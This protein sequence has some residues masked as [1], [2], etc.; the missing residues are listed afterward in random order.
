MFIYFAYPLILE[1]IL[2]WLT[3]WLQIKIDKPE[4][5]LMNYYPMNTIEDLMVFP[6]IRTTSDFINI[7]AKMTLVHSYATA[8]IVGS[9]FAALFLFLAWK[10]FEKSDI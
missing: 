8:M 5:T 7:N 10:S 9:I 3:I 4:W 6:L 1:P 2:R